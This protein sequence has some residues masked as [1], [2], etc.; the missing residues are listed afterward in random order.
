MLSQIRGD[1]Y[2]ESNMEV[3]YRESNIGSQIWGVEYR[4]LNIGSRIRG[5]EYGESNTGSRIWGVKYRVSNTGVKH[6]KSNKGS[7]I[8]EVEY[9]ESS[10]L[11]N[12]LTRFRVF[13]QCVIVYRKEKRRAQVVML[14]LFFQKAS[15]E[16]FSGGDDVSM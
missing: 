1:E 11:S 7:Q 10:N 3:E 9:R 6:G 2:G 8:Q 12:F 16:C 14:V 4:E 13:P 15:G 5:V